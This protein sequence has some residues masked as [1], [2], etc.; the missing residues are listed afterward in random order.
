[1]RPGL[2]L[3][4]ACAAGCGRGPSR[5]SLE[6][7]RPFPEDIEL[8]A[9]R[10]EET[11][12]RASTDYRDPLDARR[13]LGP[14]P[15]AIE[16]GP[17]KTLV[18]LLSRPPELVLMDESGAERARVAAPAGASA[19]APPREAGGAFLVASRDSPDLA[20]FDVDDRTIERATTKDV[21]GLGRSGLR[22]VAR[23]GRCLYGADE[24]ESALVYRCEIGEDVAAGAL[25]VP[26]A[27]TQVITT[28][29][30]VVVTSPIGHAATV[31]AL[32]AS[33]EPLEATRITLGND[34]PVFTAAA[35]ERGPDEVVVAR[36]AV[37][38]HPL[39][40]RGGSFGYVDSFVTLDRVARGLAERLATVNVA[41]LGVVTPK[42]IS[43]EAT[44]GGDE[45][46][47]VAFGYGSERAA[48]IRLDVRGDEAVRGTPLESL[49]ARTS[50]FAS[51]PGVVSFV[52][53]DGGSFAGVSPLLDA[54]IFVAPTKPPALVAVA[55]NGTVAS[56]RLAKDEPALRLGEALFY[57]TAMGPFQK[58]EGALSRFTCETCHFEGAI[59]GRVHATGRGD[60]LATT[61]PLFGL[62][63]N[64]PHFTRALDRDL[65]QMVFAEF[66]VAAQNT[67]HSERF[68]LGETA[69]RFPSMTPALRDAPHGP[70]SLRRSLMLYLAT[71]PHPR[72]TSS[73][74]DRFE[75]AEARGARVFEARC[76]S[77][78]APRLVADD[79]ATAIPTAGWEALVL[80]P[81]A[82]IVWARDGYEKTGA[83]PYV[84]PEG[85]RPS[86]LRRIAD[87]VPYFA[88]GTE[89][90]LR[91]VVEHAR[92]Q[93]GAFFHQGAPP[94]ARALTASEVDDLLAFLALL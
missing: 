80:S 62:A 41:E 5:G 58:S 50:S 28:E 29:H 46:R 59:D 48:E 23:R 11:Q 22:S 61:K 57:T 94:A 78:H 65:S 75:P 20:A 31:L 74:R 34:G 79:P 47:A 89:K 1:M 19:L 92:F 83:V 56:D 2:A 42:A 55:R 37:E 38:D 4:F 71:L 16:A 53:R 87:K 18:V 77:C 72:R 24:R 81:Q 44:R 36:G 39:D 9:V 27:P 69:L 17:A 86:S 84:H 43:L 90:T 85:A 7:V 82:P 40:R 60:I 63:N 8:V 13:V 14:D 33:G 64:G 91:A 88:N 6:A 10:L 73:P 30:H 70:A 25:A 12:L 54:I 52:T 68:D 3:V 51:L 67:D 35:F 76:A 15:V 45:I 26:R 32:S 66:R 93:E 49:G 21:R